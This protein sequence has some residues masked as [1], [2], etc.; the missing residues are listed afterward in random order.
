MQL[1]VKHIYDNYDDFYAN[2]KIEVPEGFNFSFDV[3]DRI[4]AEE[5]ERRAMIH[6]DRNN[7]TRE[8]TFAWFSEQS[9]RLAHSL[10]TRGV[11]KGDRILLM[12]YRRV[13][14]WISMLALHRIGAIA[15]PATHQFTAKDI[16]FRARHGQ[17]RG[18]IC[19]DSIVERIEET[20]SEYHGWK[21]FISVDSRHEQDKKT[22]AQASSLS[23]QD[24]KPACGASRDLLPTCELECRQGRPAE[25]H[26]KKDWVDFHTL[27]AKGKPVM[28]KPEG[29]ELASGRD[30]M[31][32]FF[33]SGTTG[34]PK[35]VQQGFTYPFGHFMTAGYWHDLGPQDVHLTLADTGWSKS[36]WG[37]L[38]GQWMHRATVFVW[39]YRGKFQPS[40]LLEILANHQITSFC[41]PPTVYR[42]LVLEDLKA[43]N[44]KHL[45]HCT[46]AGELLNASVFEDWQAAT[47]L[48]IYEGFGQTETTVALATFPNM[49]PKP[50][51]VGRPVP[52]YNIKLLDDD[53]A[54]C[55]VG[56]E[57][58]ICITFPPNQPP[59]GLFL[60]YADDP[61]Q[62]EEML[63]S[64]LY[65]T[66]DKAWE[67]EDG[68]FWFL[69]RK[70]DLIKSSGYR[71]GPF[72]VE[73]ALV[74]HPAVIE[75][76][77]VGV[78]DPVRG[79]AVKATV[80]LDIGYL[81]S[82]ELTRELQDYVKKVT[83][84]YKYPRIVEYV[85]E[86]PKTHSGKI[87][88]TVIRARHAEKEMELSSAV[89]V[90]A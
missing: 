18:I 4:A 12:L 17:L 20:R 83:A 47:G 59:P 68:Y 55:P 86:L 67:D 72:E 30:T 84:P 23:S 29:K 76:A 14:F 85:T 75:A 11:K 25:S 64:G 28:V 15:V 39:D 60:G 5:P 38:Y 51:S 74:A 79:Q 61:D 56:E 24:E 54:P 33:S 42:F 19:E 52:G 31:I 48:P 41:A 58:E 2:Y 7:N 70:D 34:M 50:G 27:L 65:R 46:T 57:G 21:H 45:R 35:M 9:A 53:G 49:D 69:G 37:K 3:I 8:Y 26:M 82:D 62:A 22:P 16:L 32:I 1:P 66:G 80:V 40:A 87:K 77:V 36:S 44:L 43:Y 90:P 81:P 73:S 88:R 6:V 71:I 78:P 89:Q 63:S 13:E 10:K